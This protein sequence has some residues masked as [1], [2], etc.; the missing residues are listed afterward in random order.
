MIRRRTVSIFAV[1]L[2]A[3]AMAWFLT[4]G[5][6]PPSPNPPGTFSFAVLGD[7]PYY[8]HEE[9]QYR[10][11]L[12]D[13]DAH[14]LR[15]VIHVGD[16]FWRP[17]SDAMYLRTRAWFRGLRHRVVYTPG[18]NEWA[19]CWEPRVGGYDPHDRLARIRRI[20]F[21][22]PMIRQAGYPENARWREGDFVFATVHLIGARNGR[23]S[24]ADDPEVNAR[25]DA[26]IAWL[27]ET[28]RENASAIVIATHANMFLETEDYRAP[29][30]RV[31]EALDEEVARFGKPVLL[32]NGE[33]HEY[34]VDH[35]LPGR[36]N[37]TRM[38]VPGSPLVG[39]VRVEV[40]PDA[41][42]PFTFEQRLV[43]RWKY[44]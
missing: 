21:D 26:A 8:H 2:A 4:K 43:P 38:Q 19:D 33:D 5:P 24:E 3:L 16:I 31:V 1:I 14:D 13:L 7:A 36:A 35:P 29:Y 30:V 12:Q 6:P 15:S 34:L 32:V 27:R 9:L 11:V 22:E 10:V 17:C 37:L 44:W 23:R 20:F 42:S 25:T 18:D 28:F 41:P 39:W 40:R